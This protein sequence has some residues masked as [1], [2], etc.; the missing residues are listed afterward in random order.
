MIHNTYIYIYIYIYIL[1]AVR[2][3]TT[4]RT[5]RDRRATL[6]ITFRR[7]ARA[8][9]IVAIFCHFSQFCEIDMSLLSLQKQPNTT[10]NLFQRG[11]EYGKYAEESRAESRPIPLSRRGVT[12]TEPTGVAAPT[13]AS[14]AC[15]R[16]QL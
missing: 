7:K 4:S 8:L 2:Q 5:L 12:P 10:P 11:V 9:S 15:P 6:E 13:G 1:S 14:A 16:V 3:P